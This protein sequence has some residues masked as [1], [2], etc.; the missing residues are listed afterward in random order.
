MEVTPAALLGLT[1]AFFFAAGSIILRRGLVFVR[2]LPAAVASVTVT[3]LIAW[4]AAALTDGLSRLLTVQVLPFFLAGCLAPGLARLFVFIGYDRIGVSR[5]M[6][7]TS[8]APLMAISA[9]I[10]FLGERPSGQVLVG[11]GLIVA[12]GVMLARRS[13]DDR[14]WRRRDMI[15]PLLG[16][17]GFASR[18][19]ISRAALVAFP[20]PMLGAAAATL[21]AVSVM[22]LVAAVQHGTRGLTLNASGIGLAALAGVCEGI[23]YLTMWRALAVGSVSIVSPLV[24]SSPV[25]TVLLALIF[26]RGVERVTWSVT[27]AAV[28]TVAGV[29]CVMLGRA[30]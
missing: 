6:T 20:H 8:A 23:A 13:A 17:V 28:V 22:W 24:V 29:V 10:V 1:A 4:T 14:S 16:A 7:L 9:A 30:G 3:A 19:A 27:A 18:D 21:A 15:F 12:G 25:F 26:L 2:P 5:A 11:A